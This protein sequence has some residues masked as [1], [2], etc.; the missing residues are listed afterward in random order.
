LSSIHDPSYPRDLPRAFVPLPVAGVIRA[1]PEDF[2]V[3]ERGVHVEDSGEHLLL[4]IEKR[5]RTSAQVASALAHAFGVAPLDVSYA[6]M[7]D[8]YAVARQWFSIRG[9]IAG[10]AAGGDGWRIL[11]CRRR[12]TKLRRGE[13]SGNAFSIR[14]R[15]VTG[16]VGALT[17]RVAALGTCGV[18]N[19]FGEQRFGRCAGNIERARTWLTAGRPRPPVS[20]LQRGLHLSTARALLF[21][22]VLAARISA[23]N[24]RT[25]LPGDV[26]SDGL[27]TAPLWGR[28][29]SESRDEAAAVESAA[30][31]PYGDWLSPLEHVGLRQQRRVL[32]AMPRALR[33]AVEGDTLRLDF[34][35]AAGQYAT[36][37]LRE[38]GAWRNAAEHSA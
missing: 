10:R 8:R 4:R 16:D 36:A 25:S 13:L 32:V 35:L 9:G 5:D 23:D 11:E 20:S 19:Y 21:N 2:V 24:W 33:Y 15:A 1:S 27:P 30:L 34:E 26:L 17:A 29:R 38:L 22:A 14:I 18:P 7:K 28:G 31:A 37:L 3:D 6:G 12:P